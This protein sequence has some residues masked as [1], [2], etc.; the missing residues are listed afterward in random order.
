MVYR[1]GLEEVM[2]QYHENLGIFHLGVEEPRSFFVPAGKEEIFSPYEW[3][4]S[5]SV[6]MIN[7]EWKIKFFNNFEDARKV[8]DEDGGIQNVKQWDTI[9]VPG[10]WQMQGFDEHQYTNIR[11]PIP[12]DPPY[13]PDENLTGVYYKTFF[14]TK[15][16]AREKVYMN[17]DGVDSCLYLWING[18]FC[19]YTQVSHATAEFDITDKVQEGKNTIV[20]IVLKWCDGT[21]LEDQDKLRMSGIFRDVYLLFR[22]KEHIRDFR[23]CTDVLGEFAQVEVVVEYNHDKNS[24]IKGTIY[25][26]SDRKIA[27]VEGKTEKLVFQIQNPIL[28]NAESPYLYRLELLYHSEKIVK[29]FGIKKIEIKDSVLLLNGKKIKLKGVNRHDSD[30]YTGYAISK[31]Q[32]MKDLFLMKAHNINAIRTSHYPNAPW[33][34]DL[35]DRLGFYVICEADLEAHGNAILYTKQSSI[36]DNRRENLDQIFFENILIGKMMRDSRFEQAVLDRIRLCAEREK[37]ATCRI[38]W[39]LGNESGFGK[40]LEKASKWL[41][42]FDRETP[43]QYESSIYKTPGAEVDMQYLDIYSRMYPSPSVCEHYATHKLLNKPFVCCEY[44]HSMGNGPGDI[45]DYW[46][47][48]YEHDTLCGGFAWEWCD[49]AVYQGEKLDGSPIFFYGGDF[50][51]KQHDGNFCVDGLVSPDRKIKPGLLEYKNVLRPARARLVECQEQYI[52]VEV[53]NCLDFTELSEEVEVICEIWENG[54]EKKRYSLKEYKIAPHESKVIEIKNDFNRNPS[55][56]EIRMIYRQRQQ[57]EWA[58]QGT[59]MGFDQLFLEKDYCFLDEKQEEIKETLVLKEDDHSF[60]IWGESERF[61]Y[62]FSKKK[63]Q[64]SSILYE[65]KELLEGTGH[66]NIWRA[67]TDNDM[68]LKN[69]WMKAGYHLIQHKTYE[70]WSE[71]KQGDI[72]IYVKESLA[73]PGFQK[74]MDLFTIW[75]IDEEGKIFVSTKVKKALDFPEL[76][77]FGLR[78]FLKKE[79]E[80]ISY[81]GLGPMESYADKRR[82][83]FEGYFSGTVSEEY[84]D[85]IKPQEHGSHSEVRKLIVENQKEKMIFEFPKGV[86]TQV[87]FYSQEQLMKTKHIYASKRSLL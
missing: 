60:M 24:D 80:K 74:L 34:Y 87:S 11:Y 53:K 59:I 32:L 77:R 31:E 21:Y 84:V 78:I 26:S 25:D 54:V 76:P 2:E 35:Y 13:V 14:L 30:P 81:W 10:C 3:Q 66:W 79:M 50:G 20:G 46:R 72:C 83:S 29:Y 41:K 63:A 71:K 28:W 69:E 48:F 33:A 65:G 1:E 27:E 73:A 64:F 5:S 43:I 39:S 37:N 86:M 42:E 58:D 51:E 23:I 55:L 19:G 36:D 45:E 15:E 12:V 49:H 17:F 22:P 56:K 52:K 44:I 7:G 40:N 47:V 67:P 38:M 85:Y 18:I 8:C 9:K 75:K 70:V 57:K 6:F 62:T 68:Y 61:I 4:K 82:A 16:R